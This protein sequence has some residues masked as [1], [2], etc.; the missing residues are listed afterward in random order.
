M[1]SERESDDLP[2][3]KIEPGEERPRGR[4]IISPEDYL[5][6]PD[7]DAF[8]AAPTKC[9]A[10]EQEGEDACRRQDEELIDLLFK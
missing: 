6:G 2:A 3:V 10:R 1:K 4:G 9:T 7:A 5:V 8:E